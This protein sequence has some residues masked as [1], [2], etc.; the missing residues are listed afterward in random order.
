VSY[1][2]DTNVLLRLRDEADP[3]HRECIV[4]VDALTDEGRQLLTCLQILAEYWVMLTRP[5]DVNGCGLPF[6]EAAIA[7]GKVRETFC[8]LAEPTD[9]AERW[10]R[11][12]LDCKVLGRQAHDARIAALMLA[13]GVSHIL[14]LNPGDFFR[15]Q[16]IAP[17]TPGEV[18]ADQGA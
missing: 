10:Q 6:E 18:C 1:L 5:R 17:V 13:H 11:L 8:C 16:G 14:T 2:L 12:V 3:R 9:M 7:L 4:A 15:Y